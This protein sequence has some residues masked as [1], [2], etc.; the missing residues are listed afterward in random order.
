MGHDRRVDRNRPFDS[1]AELSDDGD[2]GVNEYFL[3]HIY[4]TYQKDKADDVLQQLL[5]QQN[6]KMTMRKDRNH[7]F[8]KDDEGFDKYCRGKY[9]L[10]YE[11]IIEMIDKFS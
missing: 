9:R 11:S 3:K 2:L 7:P 10:L 5:L 4:S 8:H 1:V 6:E